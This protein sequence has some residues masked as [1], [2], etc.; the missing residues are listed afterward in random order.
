MWLLVVAGFGG[1]L[2]GGLFLYWLV[3]DSGTLAAALSD[4]LALAFFVD[5]LG[6]TGLLAYLFARKAPGPLKWPWFVGLSLL[7]T[8]WFGL[9]LYLWLNWRRAPEPRPPFAAWWGAGAATSDPI[10]EPR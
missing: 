7:G 1:L 9:A 2:P 10:Q 3:L 6:S 4:R 8:L 5:L